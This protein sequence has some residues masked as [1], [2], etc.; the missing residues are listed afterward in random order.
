MGKI[1]VKE[2]MSETMFQEDEDEKE[3]EDEESGNYNGLVR[4]GPANR[5]DVVFISR[6]LEPFFL[7][8]TLFFLLFLSYC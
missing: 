8:N 1:A 7:V 2:Q 4:E 3:D 5:E 6:L